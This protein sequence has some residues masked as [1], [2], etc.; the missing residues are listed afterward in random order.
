M[1][2]FLELRGRTV[3]PALCKTV[4][5]NFKNVQTETKIVHQNKFFFANYAFMK[6]NKIRINNM[7]IV[8]SNNIA[9]LL[10]TAKISVQAFW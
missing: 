8:M 10:R 1:E 9:T 7:I 4:A 5:Q 3:I 6:F 2:K